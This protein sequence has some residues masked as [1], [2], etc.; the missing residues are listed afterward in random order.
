MGAF[1]QRQVKNPSSEQLSVK[2][3]HL[4]LVNTVGS[5]FSPK[6]LNPA[7]VMA[8]QHNLTYVGIPPTS[9]QN[10]QFAGVTGK[11]QTPSG[12]LKTLTLALGQLYY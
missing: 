5:L 11:K 1:K 9:D 6:R 3:S 4:W 10:D 8:G 7:L 2:C 12:G